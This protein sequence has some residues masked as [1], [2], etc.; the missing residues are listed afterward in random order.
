[1]PIYY[2][3]ILTETAAP[4]EFVYDEKDVILYALGIGLG[5]GADDLRWVYERDLQVMPSAATVL[6]GPIMPLIAPPPG[7]RKSSLNFPLVVHGEQKV[8]LF[9]PLKP[10]DRLI[11][12][13]RVVEVLDKGADRG[14][15]LVTET[16]WSEL[17]GQPV[18]RLTNGIFARGDGGFGGRST[19][20]TA[21]HEV[22]AREP[23]A[24]MTISTRTD[25]AILYRLSGDSNP[26]HIDPGV[27]AAA[28]Y[29]RPIL[30][31]LCTYG[32]A[33]RAVVASWCDGDV[34]RLASYQARFTAPVFPGDDVCVAMWRDGD[35]VSF[36]AS[37]LER[38][39][40]VLRNGKS[41]LR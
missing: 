12:A 13:T 36:T 1:M 32:I 3:D 5:G 10:R 4:R 16:N 31:G 38:G 7:Q 28:G 8:E 39:V 33:C 2:P 41:V 19:G 21:A 20:G 9:R 35:T 6:G 25:Q 17:D 11:T 23:D 29:P 27:A 26:L 18:A 24:R 14:A 22:P 34:S 30:H 37:V 15:L 40:D